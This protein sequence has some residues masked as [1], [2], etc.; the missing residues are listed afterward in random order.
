MF[1]A[2]LVYKFSSRT[3]TQSN[4]ILS[5][6]GGWGAG[7]QRKRK[8]HDMNPVLPWPNMAILL[9]VINPFLR[10]K[11]SFLPGFEFHADN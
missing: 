11:S 1:K 4:P 10:T 3:A 2:S 5:Q 8:P 9:H 7:K 6:G